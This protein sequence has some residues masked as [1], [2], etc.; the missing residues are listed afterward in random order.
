MIAEQAREAVVAGRPDEADDILRTAEPQWSGIV[1]YR[2]LVPTERLVAYR[3]AHPDQKIRIPEHNS[4]P[5]MVS[6][7]SSCAWCR[8]LLTCDLI[9]HQY[10][11]QHVVSTDILF[12][13]LIF[14]SMTIVECRGI[15][16]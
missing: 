9:H 10:M 6:E 15:P 1:A 14:N 11:G 12:Y 4:I 3:D 2:A 16:H 8:T 13:H 7:L 5:V